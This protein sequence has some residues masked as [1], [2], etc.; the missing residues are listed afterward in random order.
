MGPE[1]KVVSAIY[2]EE[3]SRINHLETMRVCTVAVAL[4]VLLVTSEMYTNAAPM[5]SDAISL[6]DP[7]PIEMERRGGTYMSRCNNNGDCSSGCWCRVYPNWRYGQC[8]GGCSSQPL[9]GGR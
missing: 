7:E 5:E 6:E 2:T 9:P 8:I 3:A 4:V 1:S